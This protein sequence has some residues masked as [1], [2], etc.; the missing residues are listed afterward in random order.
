MSQIVSDMKQLY[1]GNEKWVFSGGCKCIL[2]LG[3]EGNSQIAGFENPMRMNKTQ[4][5]RIIKIARNRETEALHFI[6]IRNAEE[7][8]TIAMTPFVISL[9]VACP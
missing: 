6:E 3:L 4:R 8:S 7:V 5:T 1:D 2:E 9:V